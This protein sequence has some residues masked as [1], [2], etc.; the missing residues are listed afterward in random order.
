MEASCD[1]ASLRLRALAFIAVS[2][3]R[4]GLLEIAG[5]HAVREALRTSPETI[6]RIVVAEERARSEGPLREIV[7]RAKAAGIP[8]TREPRARLARHGADAPRGGVLAEVSSVPFR[9]VED[10]VDDLPSPALLLALDGVEDPRN[11]GAVARVVDGAGAHGLLVPERNTA[12]PSDVAVAASAGALLHVPLVR[13]RNVT[14]ALERLK[15]RGLWAVGLDPEASR[16]WYEFDFT[17]PVVIV[18]GS[19]GR[20][21]RPRVRRACDELVS[22]PQLGSAASLNLSVACGIVLYEAVRQRRLDRGQ[23]GGA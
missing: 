12:P 8:V 23:A 18:V 13:M 1:P 19:E 17:E 4:A 21:L 5:I 22:L 20:G 16:P 10:V 14:S 15:E 9:S 11:L 7:A 2:R 6:R 3:S